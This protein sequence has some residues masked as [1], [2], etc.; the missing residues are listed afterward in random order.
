[1]LCLSTTESDNSGVCRDSG[2]LELALVVIVL[3]VPA[4]TIDVIDKAAIRSGFVDS[5]FPLTSLHPLQ[6]TASK[7]I[8]EL[9]CYE[10]H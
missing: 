4:D 3:A 2:G 8:I 5:L 1:M 9:A 7:I 10:S 6:A